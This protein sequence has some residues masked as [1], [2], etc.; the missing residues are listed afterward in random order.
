MKKKDATNKKNPPVTGKPQP[1]AVKNFAPNPKLAL[2][3]AFACVLLYANTFHNGYVLD[4]KG[5]IQDNQY[6]QQ[7]LKGIGGIFGSDVWHFQNINLGYYRPLSLVTFAVEHQF[8]G[9][10]P[11]ISHIINVLLFALTGFL[12]C[13]LLMHIFRQY[14]PF[15]SLAIALLFV[16]HPIHTEVVANIKSRDEILSFL[17]LI[18]ALYFLLKAYSHKVDYK[19]LAFSA[20]FFYLALLSKET[21][22]AGIFIAPLV[23]Y[24][25][26]S[27]NFIN[28]LFVLSV[29]AVV[30]GVFQLQKYLALGT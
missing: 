15:F 8:F 25:A 23:I 6:V 9:N 5:I 26:T 21:A 13:L 11:Y 16:A 1:K 12:V 22:F 24:F 18:A 7:G 20:L 14:S 17:N 27:K 30:F 10:N 29:F 2:V 19:M 4:D 28:S 3:A